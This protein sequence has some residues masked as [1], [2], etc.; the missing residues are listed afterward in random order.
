MA[1]VVPFYKG[2]HGG[3]HAIV[4]LCVVHVQFVLCFVGSFVDDHIEE[5]PGDDAELVSR[6]QGCLD[7]LPLRSATQDACRDTFEKEKRAY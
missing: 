5:V 2:G 1:I 3:N 4:I 6:A 7:L